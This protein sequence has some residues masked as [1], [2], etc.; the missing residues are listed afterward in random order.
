MNALEDTFFQQLTYACS[1]IK[2]SFT[3]SIGMSQ[4]RRQL[5]LL[6]AQKGEIS[7]AALQRQLSLDG[8]MITRLVKQFEAQGMLSRRLDPR[9]NRYTLVSLTDSGRSIVADLSAAHGDFQAQLLDGI[10]RE[11]QEA[12]VH[13]LERLRTN[14]H[15][16][17]ELKRSAQ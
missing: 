4:T 1:E 10:S 9:D 3:R 6:V 15:H 14:L 12:M 8:A 16:I 2:Q 5:L 13:V 17:Q 7:H 11:E